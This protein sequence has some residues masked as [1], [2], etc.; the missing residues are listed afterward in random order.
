[1]LSGLGAC[2]E[3]L[4]RRDGI[5][6]YGG[7]AVAGNQVVQ[8]VDPW[9]RAAADRNIA[10]DGAVVSRAVQRYRTGRVIQPVLG[11]TSSAYQEMPQPAA[12][13]ADPVSAPPPPPPASK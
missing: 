2:S 5:S 7:D 8:M 13:P 10:Y 11:G 9:P 12:A 4:A 6:V 3:Y 1:M